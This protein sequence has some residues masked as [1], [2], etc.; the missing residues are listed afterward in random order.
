MVRVM[1]L[2]ETSEGS[3]GSSFSGQLPAEVEIQVKEGGTSPHKT[4]REIN[5]VYKGLKMV[6]GQAPNS[7]LLTLG[8]TARWERSERS[9]V[10]AMMAEKTGC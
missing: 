8:E 5:L 1:N 7:K 3:C 4:I 2:Q 10:G 6:T 9:R